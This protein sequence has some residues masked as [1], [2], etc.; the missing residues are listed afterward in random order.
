MT[1]KKSGS[2]EGSSVRKVQQR[3]GRR[4]LETLRDR[5]MRAAEML[6]QG[7]GRWML[8]SSWRCLNK[9]RGTCIPIP[10]DLPSSPQQHGN[11]AIAPSTS[12]PRNHLQG[13][14]N[15]LAESF[16]QRPNRGACTGGVGRRSRRHA[17]SCFD[18]LS[19]SI[20]VAVTLR[21]WLP[22]SSRVRTAADRLRC[23]WPHEI[24]CPLSRG[25]LRPPTVHKPAP[26]Q[27]RARAT[28]TPITP[29]Q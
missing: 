17:W 9:P 12:L 13:H 24:R 3:S 15:A 16:F 27:N 8:R 1:G 18:W 4:A 26:Q 23:Q 2:S 19:L 6:S 7:S 29:G 21:T 10:K 25:N 11:H 28:F 22:H 14:T 5:R 20:G